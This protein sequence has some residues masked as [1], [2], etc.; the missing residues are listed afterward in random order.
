MN[1]MATT[2][3]GEPPVSVLLAGSAG[4]VQLFTVG[5][6]RGALPARSGGSTRAF[7]PPNLSRTAAALELATTVAAAA[8]RGATPGGSQWR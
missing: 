3:R 1:S 5:P 8:A 2:R 7:V 4:P 6:D